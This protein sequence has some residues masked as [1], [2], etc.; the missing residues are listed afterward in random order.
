MSAH[1]K[2][3]LRE[4]VEAIAAELERFGV[5]EFSTR[6][7]SKRHVVVRF[8]CPDGRLEAITLGNGGDWCAHRNSRRDLRRAIRDAGKRPALI[9]TIKQEVTKPDKPSEVS[10][11]LLGPAHER[12][13]SPV[14]ITTTKEKHR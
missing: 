12:F 5:T 3:A 1:S 7:T 2:K 6:W 4:H 11:G 14:I 8:T 9:S 10:G 13:P